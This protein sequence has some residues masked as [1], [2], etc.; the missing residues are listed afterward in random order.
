[1]RAR[2]GTLFLSPA[3]PELNSAYKDLLHPA[4]ELT[5]TGKLQMTFNK[6]MVQNPLSACSCSGVTE[7]KTVAVVAAES[8]KVQVH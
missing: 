6:R 3:K 7:C 8:F 2:N 1:M 4:V 5:K